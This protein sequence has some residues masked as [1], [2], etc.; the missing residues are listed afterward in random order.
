MITA[1]TLLSRSKTS[2]NPPIARSRTYAAPLIESSGGKY[3]DSYET[4]LKSPHSEYREVKHKTNYD[5]TTINSTYSTH[6]ELR[7][8]IK[9]RNAN[10][11]RRL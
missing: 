11:S 8:P 5:S 9:S 10:G 1:C 3:S 4:K 6:S 7:P 2:K